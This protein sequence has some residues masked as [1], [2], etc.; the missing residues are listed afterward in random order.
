DAAASARCSVAEYDGRPPLVGGAT[1]TLDIV[2]EEQVDRRLSER[3]TPILD[4]G[5]PRVQRRGN[6]VDRRAA[7]RVVRLALEH[8]TPGGAQDGAG[9]WRSALSGE[10]DPRL[11]VA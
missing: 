6:G 4:V 11:D 1:R 8:G 2:L 3:A 7:E 10:R 9:A 5:M